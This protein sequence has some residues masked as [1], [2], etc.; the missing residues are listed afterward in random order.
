LKQTINAANIPKLIDLAKY[1]LHNFGQKSDLTEVAIANEHVTG[2]RMI[3]LN[4]D[5]PT[6]FVPDTLIVEVKKAAS[7]RKKPATATL[8]FR[9]LICT[10]IRFCS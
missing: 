5:Y 2:R 4:S 7:E 8:L 10:I 6:V 9:M 3:L 1:I